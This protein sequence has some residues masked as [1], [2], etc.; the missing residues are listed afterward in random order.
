MSLLLAGL[1]GCS[2]APPEKAMPP[3]EAPASAGKVTAPTPIRL[4][5]TL[6]SPVDITLAWQGDDP[7]AVGRTVEFA[8]EPQGQW[9]IIEFLQARQTTFT[10]P[11]LIPQ[12]PFYYRLRSVYGPASQAIQVTMPKGALTKKIQKKDHSWMAPRTV[13]GG[14]VAKQSIRNTGTTAAGAPTDLKAT[15]MHANGVKFTW[16][17]HASDEEGYLIEVK[18]AGSPDFRVAAVLD[19]DVNSFGLITLPEE[20]HASFRVRAFYYGPPSNVAHQTTG[21]DPSSDG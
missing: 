13:P 21:A 19:P 7:E 14:P 2:T 9:T 6:V 3:T 16:T 10:H 1:V 12:T 4:T 18:A 15:V 20:K 5:A 11:D 17:D 8:T